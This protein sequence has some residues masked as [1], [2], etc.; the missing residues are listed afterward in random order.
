[1]LRLPFLLHTKQTPHSL[2][3][4]RYI[5]VKIHRSH[6]TLTHLQMLLGQLGAILRCEGT[7]EEGRAGG[8]HG[9]VWAWLQEPLGHS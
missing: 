4:A 3:G 8:Q 9:R 1:M 5:A 6:L 2:P 7:Q